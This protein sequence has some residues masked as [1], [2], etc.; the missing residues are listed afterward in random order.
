MDMP[1]GAPLDHECCVGLH[2][3]SLARSDDSGNFRVAFVIQTHPHQQVERTPVN[4]VKRIGKISRDAHKWKNHKTLPDTPSPVGVVPE[5]WIRTRHGR[6][7]VLARPLIDTACA[8]LFAWVDTKLRG[9]RKM[10][11]HHALDHLG[12]WDAAEHWIK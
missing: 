10:I 7:C 12:T 3:E 1:P 11:A 4:P 5:V 9:I 2:A 8:K 6:H